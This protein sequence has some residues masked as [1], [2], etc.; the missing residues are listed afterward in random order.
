MPLIKQL[1][2]Q[3]WVSLMQNEKEMTGSEVAG[4]FAAL[5]ILSG[6]CVWAF[7]P[8]VA[9]TVSA[10]LRSSETAHALITPL[11]ILLL[12]YHRRQALIGSLTKG[13]VW[14]IVLLILG[15]A[16]YAG[17]TW[18]FTYGYAQNITIVIALAG[19]VL[20]TCGWKVLKLSVPMLL[21]VLAS[22]PFGAGLYTRLIIRPETYTIAASAAVLDQL[23]GIHTWIQGTD[24]FFSSEQISGVIGLGES[25][26]GV[27]LLQV[28]VAVGLFVVFS[29]I[30]S[31]WRLAV[32]ALA[33]IPIV[34]FCN[35]FRLVCWGLVVI[36]G[37]V[38]PVSSLP[39]NFS[40]I[41]SMLVLYGLFILACTLRVNLF[42]E[43]DEDKDTKTKGGSRV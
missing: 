42:I 16:M 8:E 10:A 27:R 33:A 37:T 23:P 22:I 20:V 12:M 1:I 21:L 34:L 26:R 7:W 39:R 30:R 17:A 35:L 15:F 14:G 2:Q 6:L 43:I 25:Y 5:T 40:A 9:R 19:I 36:Y 29:Q 38:G 13:S 18:P 32:A 11:A 4:S 41:S 31:Y 3:K 28:F 24:L